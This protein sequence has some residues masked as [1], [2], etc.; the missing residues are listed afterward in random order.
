MKSSVSIALFFL[1]SGFFL[2]ALLSA[3]EHSR[4]LLA[5]AAVC[6]IAVACVIGFLTPIQLPPSWRLGARPGNGSPTFSTAV[7]TAVGTTVGITVGTTV[8]TTTGSATTSTIGFSI[9][10]EALGAR[11]R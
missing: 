8:T 1:L 10:T 9:T 6:F 11:S 4:K 3:L 7:D 2:S 5:V